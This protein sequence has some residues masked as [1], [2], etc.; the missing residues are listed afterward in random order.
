VSFFHEVRAF[1]YD[2][3]QIE[4]FDKKNLD[5]YSEGDEVEVI[6]V[7]AGRGESDNGEL[8]VITAIT[9]IFEVSKFTRCTDRLLKRLT[10]MKK[11]EP[12]FFKN[13]PNAD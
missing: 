12:R 9:I 1:Q 4:G 10:R 7:Y 6:C 5:A 8:D 2:T 3:S 13:E 11:V